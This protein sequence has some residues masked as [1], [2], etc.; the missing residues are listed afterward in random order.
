MPSQSNIQNRC[1]G[2]T[3]VDGKRQVVE[4]YEILNLDSPGLRIDKLHH[5]AKFEAI[6][7]LWED[8]QY[9]AAAAQLDAYLQM[10]PDDTVAQN[11]LQD[12][13]RRVGS[14][15]PGRRQLCLVCSSFQAKNP[16]ISLPLFSSPN[17]PIVAWHHCESSQHQSWTAQR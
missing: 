11:M 8:E 5:L 6:L 9:E 12:I 14:S 7:H 13:R 16:R 4:L 17:D 3:K 15:H 10:V 1:I 2:R